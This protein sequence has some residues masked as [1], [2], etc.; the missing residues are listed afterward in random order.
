MEGKQADEVPVMKKPMRLERTITFTSV[1]AAW[2]VDARMRKSYG[3]WQ[4]NY[5]TIA[6]GA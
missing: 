1:G 3:R 4:G 5:D 6:H 2:A